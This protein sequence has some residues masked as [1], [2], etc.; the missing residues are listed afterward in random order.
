MAKERQRGVAVAVRE[1]LRKMA[2]VGGDRQA[3]F[4]QNSGPSKPEY[5]AAPPK[6]YLRIEKTPTLIN[7]TSYTSM[8]CD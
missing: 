5:T 8:P 6:I 3:L 4:F 7:P 1:D 2:L